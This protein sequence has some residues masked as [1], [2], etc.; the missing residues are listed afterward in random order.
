MNIY[1]ATARAGSLGY[2]CSPA[3]AAPGYVW[4]GSAWRRGVA[5]G[6]RDKVSELRVEYYCRLIIESGEK[7]AQL[8]AP[9]ATV[10]DIDGAAAI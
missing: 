7:Q 3:P 4:H 9:A 2:C 10:V 6:A 5:A 8:L 1:A